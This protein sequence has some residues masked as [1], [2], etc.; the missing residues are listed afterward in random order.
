MTGNRETLRLR[1]NGLYVSG[2]GVLQNSL[3]SRY[4][5]RVL[6]SRGRHEKAIRGIRREIAGEIAALDRDLLVDGNQRESPV[7][8][9]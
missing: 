6:Q 8:K 1:R 9:R 5:H 7:I 4:E 3:V 2:S